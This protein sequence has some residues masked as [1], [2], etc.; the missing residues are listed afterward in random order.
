MTESRPRFTEDG[1]REGQEGG[2]MKGHE[3]VF[4]HDEK[5]YYLDCSDDFTGIY[6]C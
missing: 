4:R 3:E 2:N 6:V 1:V 5:I